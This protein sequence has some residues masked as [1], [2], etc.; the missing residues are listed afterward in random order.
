MTAAPHA[1]ARAQL[2]TTEKLE[3]HIE[4]ET[5]L[6]PACLDTV[7][8]QCALLTKVLAGFQA[9]DD[10][11]AEDEESAELRRQD[12]DGFTKRPRSFAK[13]KQTSLAALAGASHLM[14]GDITK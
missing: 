2:L 5:E 9:G 11:K 14:F 3:A 12:E 4:D 10:T 13:R 6:R 1:S 8:Q 7:E